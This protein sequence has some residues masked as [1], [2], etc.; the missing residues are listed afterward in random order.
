MVTDLDKQPTM[1]VWDFKNDRFDTLFRGKNSAH[2]DKGGGHWDTGWGTYVNCDPGVGSRIV[3]RKMSDP[4]HMWTAADFPL[5]AGARDWGTEDHVGWENQDKRFFFMSK[6]MMTFD[7]TSGWERHAGKVYVLR[8]LSRQPG[9][10]FPPDVVRH[11][12]RDLAPAGA[13]PQAA[14]QWF[15]DKTAD[16]LYAWGFDDADLTDRTK[17]RIA[18]VDWRPG[19]DEAIQ[20]WVDDPKETSKMRRLCHMYAF[21]TFNAVDAYGQQPHAVTDRSGRYVMFQSA[22]GGRDRVD[23]FIVKVPAMEGK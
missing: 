9:H 10:R 21:G 1:I 7:N 22:W 15:Y 2:A 23:E 17:N 4:H 14:G 12:G 3:M 18:A 13:I 8:K 5:K 6:A 20:V 11:N 16:D 19:Y